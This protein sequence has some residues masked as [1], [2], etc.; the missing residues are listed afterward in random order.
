MVNDQRNCAQLQEY[1]SRKQA[2]P[3]KL[4]G[5]Y[6]KWRKDMQQIQGATQSQ[7]ST[8]Q[9]QQQRQE[10]ITPQRYVPNKRRRVRGGSATASSPSSRHTPSSAVSTVHSN[11]IETAKR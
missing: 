4:A 2:L 3:Q 9:Q 10:Q 6:F 7:A 11:M 5:R 1:I 8:T